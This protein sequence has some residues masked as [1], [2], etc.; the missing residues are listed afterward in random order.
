MNSSFKW[1]THYLHTL[2]HTHADFQCQ[3][4]QQQ[5]DRWFYYCDSAI[6]PPPECTVIRVKHMHTDTRYSN[7]MF[8]SVTKK[9]KEKSSNNSNQQR[10]LRIH[11]HFIVRHT[12]KLLVKFQ[13][14]LQSNTRTPNNITSVG[15]G[16]LY[17]LY[18][19]SLHA[20]LCVRV[21]ATA[22]FLTTPIDSATCE[23]TRLRAR[24][25]RPRVQC[26]IGSSSRCSHSQWIGWAHSLTH[27]DIRIA[28]R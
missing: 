4:T 22:R 18:K 9:K 13:Y 6:P 7:W 27:S 3:L 28:L 17:C 21:F 23:W 10:E 12:Q 14:M 11:N 5:S 24:S 2:T 26:R 1:Y 19:C 15:K 8:F 25:V 20:R 16:L